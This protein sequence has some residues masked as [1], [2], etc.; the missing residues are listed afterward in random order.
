MAPRTF[1]PKS[2]RTYRKRST[3]ARGKRSSVSAGVK[4]YVKQTIAKNIENK[5]LQVNGGSSFG[6]I[7]ESTDMNVYP[8]LPYTG[9]MT[10]P[11]NVLQGGRIGNAVKVKKLMLSYVLR[12]TAYDV[13]FNNSPCP[14]EVDMFLGHVNQL[15]G[16]LPLPGDLTFLFQTGSA[17]SAPVGS[18]RDL[19][20][21]VN[22]DYWTIKKRWR[23]KIGF[24]SNNGTGGYAAGQYAQNNDFKMNVVKKMDITKFINKNLK[25]N[26]GTATIQG[27]NLFFFYQAVKANGGVTTS[28]ELTANIEF[29]I[30]IQYEDA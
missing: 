12:P 21:T 6:N 13:A 5:T 3:A 25:F 4:K 20:S 8:M 18:L 22:T 1:R 2:K 30:D 19:I 26:D 7:L 27:K 11:Q 17:S 14:V 15:P 24:S 23:H 16:F 10:I 28:T 9:Y 29:W